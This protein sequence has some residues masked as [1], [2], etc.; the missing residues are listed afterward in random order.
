M[1]IPHL[2]N[3]KLFYIFF[4]VTDL[5]DEKNKLLPKGPLV[6]GGIKLEVNEVA[7]HEEAEL[8]YLEQLAFD[9]DPSGGDMDMYDEDQ[10]YETDE[11]DDKT[12]IHY[13]ILI[14]HIS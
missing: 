10:Y 13:L 7:I 1:H 3:W 9:L 2:N 14:A 5:D 6:E 11:L 12:V 8:K 4:I